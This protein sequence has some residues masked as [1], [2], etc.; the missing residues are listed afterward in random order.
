ME[1]NIR[2]KIFSSKVRNFSIDLPIHGYSL[3]HHYNRRSTKQHQH[4]YGIASE[5]LNTHEHFKQPKKK[6]ECVV[7]PKKCYLSE[8]IKV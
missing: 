6:N 1:R 4:L 2:F 3:E 8:N 7:W 5:V